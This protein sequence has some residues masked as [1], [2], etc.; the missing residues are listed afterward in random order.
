MDKKQLLSVETELEMVAL[1]R[2]NYQQ[3][4]ANA[5]AAHSRTHKEMIMLIIKDEV[6]RVINPKHQNDRAILD[7]KV[8]TAREQEEV[9]QDLERRLKA[10]NSLD[11][12]S[13]RIEAAIKAFADSVAPS[14]SGS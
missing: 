1:L 5:I 8:A 3:D 11:D 9:I 10:L 14:E 12:N 13:Q 2:G 7:A 6:D 4:L